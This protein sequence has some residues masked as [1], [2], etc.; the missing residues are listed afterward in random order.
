MRSASDHGAAPSQRPATGHSG[1]KRGGTRPISILFFA[2]S[3]AGLLA[4]SPAHGNPHVWVDYRITLAFEDGRLS[5]LSPTWRFDAIYSSHAIRTH[6][7]DRNGV[8]DPGEVEALRAARFEPLA[9][10]GYHVHIWSGEAK[11]EGHDV[12]RFDAWIEDARLLVEFLLPVVPPVDPMAGPVTVSLR[13]EENVVDF[14][15]LEPDYLLVSGEAPSECRFRT[16][17]GSG[18]Q[19][20]HRRP[21]TVSCRR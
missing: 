2:L 1:P 3:L 12:S 7:V 20:G 9:R 11:L 15:A 19:A 13:D 4:A 8:L 17:R 10:F 14:R 21:V 6:D 18:P 5:G 16:G